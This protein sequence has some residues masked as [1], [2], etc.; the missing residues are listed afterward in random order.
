MKL[1]GDEGMLNMI[2]LCVDPRIVNSI[3]GPKIPYWE[4]RCVKRKW[5][6]HKAL[7]V[8]VWIHNNPSFLRDMIPRRSEDGTKFRRYSW[9]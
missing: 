1:G 3:N 4:K 5:G 8:D 2:E 7:Y 9:R 6:K